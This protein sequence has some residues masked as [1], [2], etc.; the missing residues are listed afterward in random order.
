MLQNPY[1][2]LQRLAYEIGHR[3]H[4]VYVE[5]Q[6]RSVRAAQIGILSDRPLQPDELHSIG[7][8]LYDGIERR[9]AR[10]DSGIRLPD[11][12]VVIPLCTVEDAHDHAHL[13]R[14]VSRGECPT[15][16]EMLGLL[17]R[18]AVTK[19]INPNHLYPSL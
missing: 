9:A 15:P 14:C 4:I 1:G 3:G 13:S 11:V 19:I 12:D 10:H 8:V 5:N 16:D 7:Q 2:D 6:P 18:E 17:N